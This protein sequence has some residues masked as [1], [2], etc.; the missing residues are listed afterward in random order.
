ML[1]CCFSCIS[2][3]W[4]PLNVSVLATHRSCLLV[5]MLLRFAGFYWQPSLFPCEVICICESRSAPS[6]ELE[7]TT[8]RNLLLY[9]LFLVLLFFPEDRK[10]FF[11]FCVIDSYR[12]Q[13]QHI[14]AQASHLLAKVQ[15]VR[16]CCELAGFCCEG[17]DFLWALVSIYRETSSAVVLLASK[18]METSLKSMLTVF[19]GSFWANHLFYC[20]RRVS[21]CR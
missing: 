5:R 16:L 19:F 7:I 18:C 6:I 17:W 9:F 12:S 11:V 3:A 20:S 15:H 21:Y 14:G 1:G 10:S 2:K 8:C 13:S 4:F